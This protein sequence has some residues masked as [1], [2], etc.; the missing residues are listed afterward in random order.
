MGRKRGRGKGRKM[1]GRGSGRGRGGSQRG[2]VYLHDSFFYLGNF[3]ERGLLYLS[4]LSLLQT[5]ASSLANCLSTRFVEVPASVVLLGLF[6][7]HKQQIG[8]K[9]TLIYVQ[10]FKKRKK[11][12]PQRSV[13]LFNIHLRGH[14]FSQAFWPW[15]WRMRLPPQTFWHWNWWRCFPTGAFYRMEHRRKKFLMDQRIFF[16]VRW[17]STNRSS[18]FASSYFRLLLYYLL[19]LSLSPRSILPYKYRPSPSL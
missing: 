8:Q 14:F 13:P 3:S 5:P 12:G 10:V 4:L 9:L 7:C 15:N 18:S 6:P 1:R 16:W 17:F 19:T 11:G 2:K